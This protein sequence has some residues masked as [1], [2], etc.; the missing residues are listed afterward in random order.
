MIK[1]INVALI[2]R[3]NT[4][5]QSTREQNNDKKKYDHKQLQ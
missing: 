3:A 1:R 5:E 4:K 2:Y